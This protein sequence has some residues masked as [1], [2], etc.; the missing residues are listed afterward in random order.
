MFHEKRTL[1]APKNDEKDT[2][3]NFFGKSFFYVLA[4]KD[5]S[6]D[7]KVTSVI[8]WQKKKVVDLYLSFYK[9]FLDFSRKAFIL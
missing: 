4:Q 7:P 8:L 6:V 1:L 3:V 2:S 5:T 9:Y